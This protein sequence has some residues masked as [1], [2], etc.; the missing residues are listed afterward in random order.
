MRSANGR[1]S[2]ISFAGDSLCSQHCSRD[3]IRYELQAAQGNVRR[4]QRYGAV[5]HRAASYQRG[6]DRCFQSNCHSLG[7]V[8]SQEYG[9]GI[10]TMQRI[11]LPLVAIVVVAFGQSQSI[12]RAGSNPHCHYA[13]GELWL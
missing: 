9:T 3:L 2:R 1:R 13:G 11:V 5:V 10:F 7:C 8:V 6:L 12:S 4:Q